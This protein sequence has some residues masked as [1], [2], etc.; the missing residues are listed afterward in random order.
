MRARIAMRRRAATAFSLSVARARM[1]GFEVFADLYFLADMILNAVSACWAVACVRKMTCL[2]GAMAVRW[3]YRGGVVAVPCRCRGG[4][5]VVVSWWAGEG[6]RLMPTLIRL[7]RQVTGYIRD[8]KLISTQPDVARHYALTWFVPDVLSTFPFHRVLTTTNEDVLRLAKF[9]RLLK[10]FK[11]LRLV[12]S[13]QV[14]AALVRRTSERLA[15]RQDDSTTHADVLMLH[16]LCSVYVCVCW[17]A[18]QVISRRISQSHF[19]YIAHPSL[20]RLFTLCCGLILSWHCIGCIWF[21]LRSTG[22]D[23][24]TVTFIPMPA[25]G[26]HPGF[27][28][29]RAAPPNIPYAT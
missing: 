15:H 22:A 14:W 1:Q 21:F 24:L 27:A 5:M 10:L 23:G 3:R 16:A 20:I 19:A 4:A 13:S 28:F 6:H 25:G 12:R 2:G 8:G 11:L 18:A 7:V 17:T 29:V 26:P 9:I